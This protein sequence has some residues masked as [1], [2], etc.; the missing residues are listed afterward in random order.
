[1]RA[2]QD[3]DLHKGHVQDYLPPVDISVRIYSIS[4]IDTKQNCFRYVDL[5]RHSIQY[6]KPVNCNR[7]EFNV[8]MDWE[9]PSLTLLMR[10]DGTPDPY[11]VHDHFSPR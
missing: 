9:D 5:I 6:S 11:I 1:M 4:N 7:C 8:M 3:D 10:D 2:L